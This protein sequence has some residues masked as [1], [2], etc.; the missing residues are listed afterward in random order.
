MPNYPLTQLEAKA[1][2]IA[3]FLHRKQIR[4]NSGKPYFNEHVAKV[5][6]TLKLY[7]K[8]EKKLIM[9]LLHD[10]LEDCFEDHEFEEGFNFIA[11]TFSHEIAVGVVQLTTSKKILNTVFKGDKGEYLLYKMQNMDEDVLQ[12]KLADR[13]RNLDDALTEKN[14]KYVNQTMMIMNKL[15]IRSSMHNKITC[16]I[17]NDIIAKCENVLKILK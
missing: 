9:A 8:S 6:G 16:N 1:W 2:G 11:N 4:K 14:I 3:E 17:A 15:D 10:T 7:T 5:N 13:L 12:V